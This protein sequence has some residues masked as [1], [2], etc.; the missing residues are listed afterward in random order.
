MNTKVLKHLILI[1]KKNFFYNINYYYYYYLLFKLFKIN[2]NNYCYEII[3]II[4]FDI[5]KILLLL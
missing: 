5:K 2:I 3:N 4:F 1:K